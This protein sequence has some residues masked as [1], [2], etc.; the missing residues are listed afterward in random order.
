MG[1][2]SHVTIPQHVL[3][4]NAA[5]LTIRD[6][7]R[8]IS[9]CCSKL[10]FKFQM[11]AHKKHSSARA[12]SAGRKLFGRRTF[13][14]AGR[15]LA[16][17]LLAAFMGCKPHANEPEH[18]ALSAQQ[19]EAATAMAEKGQPE[20]QS[21]LGTAY[22]RGEGVKQDYQQAAKW[23]QR[24]AEQGNAAAQTALG[25][26]F[27]AGQ[28]VPRDN[29]KAAEWFRRAAEQ[30]AATAQYDLAAL[31][32]IGKGV[33]FD[34]SQALRWYLLA[35]NQGDS[36][37]QYNVG[38]RYFEGHGITP[39]PVL[40]YQ[41]LSL[42]SDQGV[43]DAARALKTLKATMSSEQISKARKLVHDFKPSQTGRSSNR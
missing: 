37:A 36:L 6:L 1:F 40:A 14:V 42:A 9:R 18:L 8:P 29:G 4:S 27:E 3:Q 35:A 12:Q 30:G 32:A 41:W 11:M 10:N 22:A 13:S 5:K 28:G 24:A 20:A 23:Y 21:S 7:T 43:P 17:F 31:Y 26:L 25:E 34:N 38:M 33:P 39:D 16:V 19:L 2:S 15:A